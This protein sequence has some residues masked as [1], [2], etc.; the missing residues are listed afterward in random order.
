MGKI[1]KR[2][3]VRIGRRRSEKGKP[4][5]ERKKKKRKKRVK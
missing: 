4:E 5:K 3:E 2:K 1:T